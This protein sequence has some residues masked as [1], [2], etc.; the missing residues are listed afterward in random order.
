MGSEGKILFLF[1]CA[2]RSNCEE[3]QEKYHG[4]VNK[5]DHNGKGEREINPQVIINLNRLDLVNTK[6]YLGRGYEG[7]REKPEEER[8]IWLRVYTWEKLTPLTEIDTRKGLWDLIGYT[9][10]LIN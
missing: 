10:Y 2:L 7:A 5:S 8:G 1:S 3:R 6:C 9:P 4:T